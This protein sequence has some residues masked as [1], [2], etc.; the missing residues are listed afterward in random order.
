MSFIWQQKEEMRQPS[1]TLPAET[2]AHSV[3]SWL[4]GSEVPGK[5]SADQLVSVLLAT[6]SDH[7]AVQSTSIYQVYFYHSKFHKNNDSTHILT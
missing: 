6:D 2:V 3:S 1:P 4:T 7:L 5:L